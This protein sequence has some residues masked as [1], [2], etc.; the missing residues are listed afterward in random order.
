MSLYSQLTSILEAV[1]PS[2]TR[3]HA[4]PWWQGPTYHGMFQNYFFKILF[5]I[6]LPLMAMTSEKSLSSGLQSKFPSV[7]G[8]HIMTRS[9]KQLSVIS[10]FP[11]Y[12]NR[13]P[14][15]MH[16]HHH[17]IAHTPK[18]QAATT[19]H[20]PQ[21]L[22]SCSVLIDGNDLASGISSFISMAS[23]TLKLI[24]SFI[25]MDSSHSIQT[26][27]VPSPS[28]VTHASLQDTVSPSTRSTQFSNT[29]T[30]I[31]VAFCHHMK[32]DTFTV[33]ISHCTELIAAV[34]ALYINNLKAWLTN[35]FHLETYFLT[36][37]WL[38]Q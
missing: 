24:S 10:Q 14:K 17:H 1:P 22:T 8:T 16:C 18:A 27:S 13:W 7:Y 9:R 36:W 23:S 37:L 30:Q 20:T 5:N 28:H 2:A 25:S 11:Y 6:I 31:M 26:A 3:G 38:F 12:I 32:Q 19:S 34:W 4:T 33:S 35:N 21:S 29:T 15:S